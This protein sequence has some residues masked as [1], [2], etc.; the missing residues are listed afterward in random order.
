M[1]LRP[2]KPIIIN[3]TIVQA[4]T[5]ETIVLPNHLMDF[6]IR[7][8]NISQSMKVAFKSGESGSNYFTLDSAMPAIDAEDVLMNDQILYIQSPNVGAVLEI[9]AYR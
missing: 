8:R 7:L 2:V 6:T 9:V 4:N 1:A 3:Y 5:E